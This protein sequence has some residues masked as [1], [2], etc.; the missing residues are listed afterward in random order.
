MNRLEPINTPQTIQIYPR[1]YSVAENYTSGLTAILTETGTGREEEISDFTLETTS[2]T[3]GVTFKSDLFREGFSYYIEFSLGETLW[4]REMIIA[5]TQDEKNE[6]Y[7]LNT[8]KYTEVE[9]ETTR[10]IV[11]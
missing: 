9:Q 4:C 10:Y 11:L 1:D 5:T 6:S 2:N 8:D 3:I 7:T